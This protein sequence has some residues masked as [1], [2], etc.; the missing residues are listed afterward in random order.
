MHDR[1]GG[2]GFRHRPPQWWLDTPAPPGRA[3][4]EVLAMVVGVL[5]ARMVAEDGE[6]NWLEG[7]MLLA[8]YAILALAFFFLP[9]RTASRTGQ[10]SATEAHARMEPFINARRSIIDKAGYLP[11]GG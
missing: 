10:S 4:L 3:S 7:L 8:V 11:R 1:S 6:S 9:E 2:P 5:I